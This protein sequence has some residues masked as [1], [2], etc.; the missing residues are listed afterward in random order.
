MAVGVALAEQRGRTPHDGGVAAMC[1]WVVRMVQ[2]GA[3]AET[4]AS[5][6]RTSLCVEALGVSKSATT[7]HMGF[8]S[9]DDGETGRQT[10]QRV[11]ETATRGAIG[12]PWTAASPKWP[13][14]WQLR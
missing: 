9:S 3:P 12:G 7:S 13:H 4:Q 8:L 5:S 6:G 11:F 2:A 10:V 14:S 1:A